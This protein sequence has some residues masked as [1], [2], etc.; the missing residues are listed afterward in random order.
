MLGVMSH[1]R[2]NLVA[3]EHHFQRALE[4]NASYTEA[5]L[6]LAVTYNDRGKYEAARDIYRR[7]KAGPGGSGQAPEP[8]ARGKLANMHAELG[9]AYA[10]ASMPREAIGE[11][12][13]AVAL[14]P[15][16]ADLRTRLGTLLREQNEFGRAREHYE[17]ALR[18]KPN[19]VPALIQLGVT[20]MASGDADGAQNAWDRVLAVE[21]EN[22]QAKMYLRTLQLRRESGMFQA[23][24]P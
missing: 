22:A 10:D 18:G 12:E 8:F 3:A 13:R 6:N 24:K 21:P 16:F 5:A 1:L 9:E 7:I 2:G 17:A 19:Y 20:L 23:A 15:G 11:Y 4:L 14:C